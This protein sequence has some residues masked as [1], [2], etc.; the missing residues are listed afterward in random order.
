MTLSLSRTMTTKSAAPEITAFDRLG[1]TLFLAITIH[2]LIILGITFRPDPDAEQTAAPPLEITLV[3]PQEQEEVDKAKLLAQVSQ[4]GG[5]NDERE[6][7]VASPMSTPEQSPT[8][9][10]AEI[11]QPRAAPQ[12]SHAKADVIMTTIAPDAEKVSTDT[13]TEQAVEAPISAE[14]LVEQSVEIA[15]L[16]AEINR[17]MDDYAKRERHRYL[18]ARTRTFRDAVYL[19]A[20]QAKIEQIGNLNYPEEAKR[21]KL[22]GDLILD[23]ALNPDGSLREV[24][25]RHSSGKKVLDDAAIRIVRLAAPFAPFTDAMRKDTDVLHIVRTWRFLDGARVQAD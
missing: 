22:T 4:E 6:G 21:L 3:H 5:G 13:Q 18:S 17:S 1:L 8:P 14:Q 25:V 23:V 7:R 16:S 20:W 2:A 12:P 10:Q 9:Q 19:D 11:R 15:R 24:T